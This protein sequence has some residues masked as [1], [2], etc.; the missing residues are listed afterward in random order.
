MLNFCVRS[1]TVEEYLRAI[2]Y[3]RSKHGLAR[4]SEL[5]KYLGISKAGVSESLRSLCSA[6]LARQE[7]YGPISLTTKG[8]RLASKMTFKHRVIEL[9]LAK[10]LRLSKSKVHAEAS[11]IEHS[12]SDETVRRLYFFLGKP[13]R[14]PHGSPIVR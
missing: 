14:D 7:K 6:G 12:V 1:E 4:A 5:A 3:L 11:R 10:T 2:L 13:R 9:F 8:E